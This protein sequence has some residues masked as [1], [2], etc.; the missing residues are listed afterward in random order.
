MDLETGSTL[1][2]GRSDPIT[3]LVGA[4]RQ[5]ARVEPEPELTPTPNPNPRPTDARAPL[6]I[7]AWIMIVDSKARAGASF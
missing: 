6:P 7:D 3:L 5:G 2:P 4:V 1:A